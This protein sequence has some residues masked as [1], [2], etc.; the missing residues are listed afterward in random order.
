MFEMVVPKNFCQLKPLLRLCVAGCYV[1]LRIKFSGWKCQ[2]RL[3]FP[4]NGGSGLL[5]IIALIPPTPLTHLGVLRF[6]PQS[7]FG[8]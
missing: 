1:A 8:G 4:T 7:L 2:K 3:A 5:S 6:A